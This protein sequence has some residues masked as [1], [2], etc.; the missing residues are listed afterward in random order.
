MGISLSGVKLDR[1]KFAQQLGLDAGDTASTEDALKASFV[2]NVVQSIEAMPQISVQAQLLGTWSDPSLKLT[3]NLTDVLGG[4]IKTTFGNAVKEQ[5]AQI[6]AKLNDV[7]TKEKAQL[8]A[9]TAELE[10]KVNDRINALQA[11]VDKK[12]NEASGISLSPAGGTS[13][14]KLPSLDKLFKK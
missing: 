1:E 5:R 7:M 9:K 8:D 2:T 11:E 10:K 6:E 4:A 3:S 12:I 13:P 14:V